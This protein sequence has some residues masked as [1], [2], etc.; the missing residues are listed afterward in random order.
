MDINQFLSICGGISIV[1]GA[2]GIIWKFV[3]PVVN[4]NRRI[5]SLE[6]KEKLNEDEI[7]KIDSIDK[8]ISTMEGK[9]KKDFERLET[10]E[11]MQKSQT[12]C[13]AAMLNHQITGNGI[14]KMKKIQEELLNSII[15]N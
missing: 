5:S 15:E 9:L 12:K 3:L 14:E 2:V 10:I 8:R 1:G 4:V 13:L 6:E 11:A 7:S